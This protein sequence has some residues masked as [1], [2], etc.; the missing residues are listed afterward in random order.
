M[1]IGLIVNPIAGMGGSVALKGTDGA[2]ILAEAQRRGYAEADPTFDVEGIDAAQKLAILAQIAFG[3]A[4][5][6]EAIARR[7]IAKIQQ[8]D[9]RFARE[10]GYTIKLLA[11]AWHEE[12]HRFASAIPCSGICAIAAQS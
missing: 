12:H 6:V 10:L 11:E 4:V 5:P 1:K 3:V 8:A 7:G 2:Q 9:I